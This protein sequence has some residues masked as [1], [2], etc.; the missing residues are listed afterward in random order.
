VKSKRFWLIGILVVLS[1]CVLVFI[2]GKYNLV[3]P[4]VTV[5]LIA[6]ADLHNNKLPELAEYMKN[7]RQKN[8]NLILVDAGDFF[9]I[10]KYQSEMW[11]WFFVKNRQGTPPIIDDMA[12][13]NYDAVVLGNHE[14]VANYKSALDV[15]VSGLEAHNISVLSAN[16]YTLAGTNYVTPYII[17]GIPSR[18]GIIK[19]GILGL[20]LKEVAEQ[21]GPCELKDMPQYKGQ[22]E[23]N[24]LLLEAQKWTPL[25]KAKGADI[26]IAVV[27]SGEEPKNP[28]HPG[29]KIKAL[30][31]NTADIDAIVAA[32]THVNIPQH[33]YK[34]L[35]GNTVIV[36]QPGAN[37]KY[38]SRIN[39]LLLRE[40]GKWKVLD[41]NSNTEMIQ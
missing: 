38:I 2:G 27:H 28:K 21:V 34:N 30:A 32:H 1:S 15:L 13:I 39:F 16:T 4:Q 24:D 36:T 29:N 23:M 11:K 9:D 25:M 19:V 5:N 14:F 7:E 3:Q 35:M 18:Y 20:T 26:I 22:L 12:A 40:D 6:S 33:Q 31:K 41:K 37:G 8:P 10:G 17:K